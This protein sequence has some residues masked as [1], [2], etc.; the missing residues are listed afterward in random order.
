V[1]AKDELVAQLSHAQAGQREV[2][3]QVEVAETQLTRAES[4][5]KAIEARR[6]ELRLAERTCAGVEA[7]IE[8]IGSKSID[9]DA[10][11]KAL[12]DREAIVTAVKAELDTVHEIGARSKADLQYLAQHRD[13]MATLREQVHDLL[14]K[15][16]QTEDRLAFVRAQRKSVDEVSSQAQLTMNLFEEVRAGLESVGEQ[17]VMID[18]VGEKLA[19]LEFVTQAAERAIQTMQ[20]EREMAERIERS[21]TQIRARFT[22]KSLA[23]SLAA[24]A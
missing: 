10:T 22:P 17:K 15:T 18:R 20:Q 2:M 6:T 23:R 24:S 21:L 4:L 9:L 13:E 7:K 14:A 1:A 19:R 5:H 3:C 11:L 16:E 12:A 8:L